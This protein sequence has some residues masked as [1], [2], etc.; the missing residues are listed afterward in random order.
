[1]E[2]IKEDVNSFITDVAENSP[3]ERIAKVLKVLF[4]HVFMTKEMGHIPNLDIRTLE[5]VN[6][7]LKEK[8]WSTIT[9]T[10]EYM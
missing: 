10:V 7:I 6:K 5:E 9:I 8:I 3:D 1:M 2:K 4:S